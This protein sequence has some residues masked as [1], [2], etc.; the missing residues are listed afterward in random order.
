[1]HWFE[2]RARRASAASTSSLSRTM[3]SVCLSSTSAKSTAGT[4]T[5][6]MQAPR[7]HDSPGLLNARAISGMSEDASLKLDM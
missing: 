1:M 4:C 3:V 5:F 6:C 7:W 2:Q